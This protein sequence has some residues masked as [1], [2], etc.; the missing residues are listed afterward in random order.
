[1][2][3]VISRWLQSNRGLLKG[4]TGR[5]Y[6]SEAS[7]LQ[8]S[9]LLRGE[10]GY[11]PARPSI[12]R[13]E[14]ASAATAASH[15][16]ILG[17]SRRRVCPPPLSGE[18]KNWALCAGAP[19]TA[20]RVAAATPPAS[21]KLQSSFGG[22]GRLAYSADPTTTTSSVQTPPRRNSG[23]EMAHGLQWN[24]DRNR[25]V[26]VAISDGDGWLPKYH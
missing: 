24:L 8:S 1:M 21:C 12:A 25:V 3:H 11:D 10:H 13:E 20:S 2:F 16:W 22:V 14:S 26:A 4:V 23:P 7:S 5:I 9:A 17:E 15:R 18:Q 19:A 6:P